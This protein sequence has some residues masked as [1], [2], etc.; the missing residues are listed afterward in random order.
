MELDHKRYYFD[1][2]G[3]FSQKYKQFPIIEKG[4]WKSMPY[5]FYS[6]HDGV[7]DYL[8]KN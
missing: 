3:A 1:D 8:N 5:V 4:L 2:K 6:D 7:A